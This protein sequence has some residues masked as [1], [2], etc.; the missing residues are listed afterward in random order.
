M[1]VA[2]APGGGSETD[3]DNGEHALPTVAQLERSFHRQL[4]A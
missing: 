4:R 1:R 2:L 3:Q